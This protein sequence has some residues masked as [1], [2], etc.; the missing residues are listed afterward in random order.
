MVLE[1]ILKSG[2]G[3][4]VL[5]D[6]EAVRSACHFRIRDI[7]NI[8]MGRYATYD[9]FKA[10]VIHNISNNFSDQKNLNQIFDE[11]VRSILIW[12]LGYFRMRRPSMLWWMAPTPAVG[13]ASA[14]LTFNIE[15]PRIWQYF[16]RQINIVRL[17]SSD[18]IWNAWCSTAHRFSISWKYFSKK[19]TET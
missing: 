3:R 13:V 1:D 17:I 9:W 18:S 12:R 4:E 2:L 14:L 6:S 19:E 16:D 11:L 15:G 5:A 10:C 7:E 8:L